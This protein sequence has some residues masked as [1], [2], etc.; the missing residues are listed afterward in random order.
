MKRKL[1]PR[2]RLLF[3]QAMTQA[4]DARDPY[5]A[6]H[7]DRVSFQSAVIAEAMGL[8]PEI[9]DTIR[10]G[11]KLHDIGK[12]GMPEQ[13]LR[14]P[15]KLSQKERS[16]IRLHPRIGKKILEEIGSFEDCMPIVELH[17]EQYDGSGYPYGLSGSGIPIT[18]RVV[19]VADVYDAL[20]TDRT[21]RVAMSEEKVL[22]TFTAGAGT[23][24][25]PVVVEALVTVRHQTHRFSRN[26]TAAS[27]C[28][29]AV[30]ENSITA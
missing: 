19:Q 16:V 11:A 5:T 13:L 20:T 3:V 1:S 28:R 23:M 8:P 17:H 6:G 25:D 18:A 30:V 14:K 27:A 12:V 9:I 2:D 24:F 7:S 22:N 15:G 10:I 21:Y 29:P 26:A 4:L